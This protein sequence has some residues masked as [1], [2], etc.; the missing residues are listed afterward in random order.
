MYVNCMYWRRAP[1]VLAQWS[2]GGTILS[3]HFFEALS[4]NFEADYFHGLIFA[5]YQIFW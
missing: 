1:S 4:G 3:F 5:P 2:T